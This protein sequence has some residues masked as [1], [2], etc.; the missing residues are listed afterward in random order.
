MMLTRRLDF[1]R[2]EAARGHSMLSHPQ[3]ATDSP[4]WMA[5]AE[6]QGLALLDSSAATGPVSPRLVQTA[7]G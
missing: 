7:L 1:D 6:R 5:A 4:E 3:F 2:W